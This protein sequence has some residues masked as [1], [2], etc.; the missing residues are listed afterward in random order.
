MEVVMVDLQEKKDRILKI[1]DEIALL[2][3]KEVEL[4]KLEE[5]YYNDYFNLEREEYAHLTQIPHTCSI[6]REPMRPY[7]I[8]NVDLIGKMIATLFKDYENKRMIVMRNYVHEK[9]QNDNGEYPVM[10]PI[11]IIKNTLG[12][13]SNDVI[14]IDYNSNMYPCEYPTDNP[15]TWRISPTGY[16]FEASNYSNLIFLTGNLTFDNKNRE[17]IEELVYSMAYYQKQHGITYMNADKTWE[18]FKKIYKK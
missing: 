10:Y 8:L 5:E 12:N 14:K 4:K 1:K 2:R 6:N 16:E 3:A 9:W 17:F 13:D 7:S 18:V 11:L 15:T